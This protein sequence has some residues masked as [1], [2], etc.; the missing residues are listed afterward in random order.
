MSLYEFSIETEKEGFYNITDDIREAVRKSGTKEGLCTVCCMH[1]SAGVTV[2]ENADPGVL[3]DLTAGFNRAFPDGREFRHMDGN[4]A[5]H[6]KASCVGASA[7]VIVH[8]GKPLLGKFQ[9][10]YL[11]EFEGPR[12]RRYYVKVVSG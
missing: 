2:N 7:A 1:T 5:A 11:C 10:V 12:T 6:L 9:G 8:E 4:S 3:Y